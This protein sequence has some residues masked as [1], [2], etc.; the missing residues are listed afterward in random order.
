MDFSV[1]SKFYHFMTGLA[2][3]MILSVLFLVTSIPLFTLPL[4]AVALCAAVR[5]CVRGE[6]AHCA[7]TY[8]RLLKENGKQGLA[9]AL[10][11][12]AALAAAS[13][14]L[15]LAARLGA[16]L[17]AL[18]GVYIIL[19]A[20]MVGWLHIAVSYIG[21]FRASFSQVVKNSL[22]ICLVNLPNTISMIVLFLVCFGGWALLLPRSFFAI[23][24]LPGL[25]ALVSGLLTDRIFK[26]YMEEEPNE[27]EET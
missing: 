15:T 5:K 17:S 2:D 8:F 26:K 27:K 14:V 21:K 20:L 19:G 10:T 1:N 13:L 3:L 9:L 24:L 18:Y 4:S 6:E 7:R 25:Y 22:V 23:I 16:S 12:L 11:C